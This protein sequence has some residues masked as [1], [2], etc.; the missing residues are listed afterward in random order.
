MFPF[1]VERKNSAALQCGFDVSKARV[2]SCRE[3]TSS[4]SSSERRRRFDD[5]DD[6]EDFFLFFFFFADADADAGGEGRTGVWTDQEGARGVSRGERRVLRG[7]VRDGRGETDGG[8]GD[9]DVCE[10]ERG[11]RAGVSGVLGGAL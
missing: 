9:G 8:D 1:L 10:V 4:R 11:V 6:G 7:G 3:N 5:D 2:V